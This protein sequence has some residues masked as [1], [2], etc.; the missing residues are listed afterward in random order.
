MLAYYMLGFI[1]GLVLMVAVFIA[2]IL[3]INKRQTKVTSLGFRHSDSNNERSYPNYSGSD[4]T[5]V[6]L[7]CGTKVSDRCRRCRPH[8]KKVV[9]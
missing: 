4:L 8:M 9:F 6:C 7:S 5:Y 2:V 3:Y 1:V